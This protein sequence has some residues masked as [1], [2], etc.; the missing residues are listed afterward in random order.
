M[1]VIV[2]NELKKQLFIAKCSVCD[3]VTLFDRDELRSVESDFRE[4]YE[5]SH[6]NCPVCDHRDVAY[7]IESTYGQQTLDRANLTLE[8]ALLLYAE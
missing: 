6:V 4:H 2:R 8:K 1:K 7:P 5:Y 3:S